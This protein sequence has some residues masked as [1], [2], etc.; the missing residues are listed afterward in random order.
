MVL[1]QRCTHCLVNRR[2]P[3]FDIKIP[4][5]LLVGLVS[6][7]GL[8]GVRLEAENLRVSPPEIHEIYLTSNDAK[9]EV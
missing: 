1:F 2:T 7:T 5:V 6:L 4:S 8:R 9:I 3:R